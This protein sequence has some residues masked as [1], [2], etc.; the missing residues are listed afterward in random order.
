MAGAPPGL[1]AV[2]LVPDL[3]RTLRQA[4]LPLVAVVVYGQG[5]GFFDLFLLGAFLAAAAARTTAHFVSL[6]YRVHEG[7]LEIRSGILRASTG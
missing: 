5:S 3:W 2:N 1:L 7:K 6:R 4:W